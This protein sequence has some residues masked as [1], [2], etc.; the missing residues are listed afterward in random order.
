[1][2]QKLTNLK[3][4]LL[5]IND[6]ESAGGLLNWDQSTYMP[7]GGS[8]ARA[9]QCATLARI[10]HEKFISPTI[11]KLLDA[12]RPYEESLP[13]DSDEASLIRVTR[14]QYEKAVQIPSEFAQR[15]SQHQAESYNVWIKARPQNDFNAVKPYLEK[16][17]DLSLELAGFFP[18]FEHPADPLI[19]FADYGMKVSVLRVIF[20]DLRKSIVPLVEKI[21]SLPP[22]DNS[23]L[24][25]LFAEDKQ[26]EF[27]KTVVKQLGY[28]FNNGRL[29]KTAHPFT[30]KF[31]IEDVRITT[32]VKENDFGE[33]LFSTIHEAGHAMYEQGISSAYEGTPLA[34]GT[35]SG[36]HES[37][38]RLWENQVG[39][40]LSF[41][42]YFYPNLKKLFPKQFSK[43][44]LETFYRAINKVENS[45][46]RTDADEVTYNLH[47]IIRF[48]LECLLLERKLRVKDL[49]EAWNERYKSDIG[50]V[51]PTN[52]N[53]VMQDVHWYAGIVGGAFQGYTLGNILSA[54]FYDT[55]LKVNPDIELHIEKGIYSTLH[56]WLRDNIYKHGSKFTAS[57]LV[58]RITGGGID[59]TPFVRYLTQ[60]YGTLYSL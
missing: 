60:K 5:E 19:D 33:N 25:Q 58:K 35:S 9:R 45:L 15:I 28:D 38:S 49:P 21:T 16:T 6:I 14:R 23:S 53:G 26:M 11:G 51:S 2:K 32:R 22:V 55:A 54:Q 52:A 34:H 4:L 40:N 13:Y 39:R 17:V 59:S 41:W 30:T 46:I 12:L 57:E 48:D 18:G 37:Q 50:I 47:V 24:K 8:V 20:A 3:N 27:A 42:K 36:V 7:M 10:A 44:K 29:D 31:S 1:M 56:D 43:V